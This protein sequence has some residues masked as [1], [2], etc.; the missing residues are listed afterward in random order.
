MDPNC[1]RTAGHHSDDSL[2]GDNYDRT[3]KRMRTNNKK[4]KYTGHTAVLPKVR[5]HNCPAEAMEDLCMHTC[6]ASDSE[7]DH[8]YDRLDIEPEPSCHSCDRETS[9]PLKVIELFNT[10]KSKSKNNISVSSLSSACN[11]QSKIEAKDD[12]EQSTESVHPPSPTFRSAANSSTILCSKLK[13][14]SPAP[15][16]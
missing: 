4:V 7:S 1:K 9:T 12:Q 14:I 2:S 13:I 15:P 5:Q 6:C 3:R 11:S 10:Q 8:H 16:N